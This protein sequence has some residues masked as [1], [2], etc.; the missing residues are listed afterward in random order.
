MVA[1]TAAA[2]A[3]ALMTERS[4][5]A[6]VGLTPVFAEAAPR[7]VT[8]VA[9]RPNITVEGVIDSAWEAVSQKLMTAILVGLG[10]I[11]LAIAI[12]ALSTFAAGFRTSHVIPV[13]TF[14]PS[15]DLRAGS[16]VA[17]NWEESYTLAAPRAADLGAAVLAG[18]THQRNVDGLKIAAAAE[19][20]NRRAA[21][22]SAAAASAR[23]SQVRGAAV[24]PYTRGTA[25]GYAAGTV[26]PARITIYGCTGPGGGF[27]GNMASGIRV[28]EGAAACSSNLPFG[29]RFTV[30]GD[31]SGRT[32][33]CLDR[34]HLSSTWVDIFFADTRTGMAWQS[35]L[36]T[37][38][39]EITIVN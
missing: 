10:V 7:E 34:G 8:A 4:R 15:E 25:S 1:G 9:P 33:E 16:G 24:A 22:Q 6:R 19:E 35:N 27:C 20:L 38:K 5:P 32:Y 36:G 31:P 37:T 3:T 18:I 14:G 21:A 28:F 11:A 30:S 29:T 17:G 13:A 26:L 39:G 12:P 2:V 23:T